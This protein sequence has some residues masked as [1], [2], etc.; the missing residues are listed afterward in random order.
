MKKQ[1]VQPELNIIKFDVKDI[2]TLSYAT[3]GGDNSQG[4]NSAWIPNTSGT[5]GP[6]KPGIPGKNPFAF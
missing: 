2:I 5:S 1:Y 4:F 3:D 6:N